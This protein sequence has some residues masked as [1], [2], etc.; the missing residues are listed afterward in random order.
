MAADFVVRFWGVRGS[1]AASGPE[2]ATVGGHT[3]CVEVRAGDEVIIFDAGTGI[4]PLAATLPTPIAAA[5]FVSHFHWDHIQGFPLFRPAYLPENAFTLYGPGDGPDGLEASLRRQ[6]QAPN[7]PVPFDALR[8][9]LRFGAI[10][11]GDEV[12]LG[13]VKVRAAALHHPQGCLGYRIAYGGASV[14][15]ATDTEQMDGLLDPALVEFARGA[16]LLICDAQYSEQEYAGTAGPCRRGW[17]HT[18]VSEASRVAR[19][20][21]VG[22]LALFHHDPSH[23][24]RQVLAMLR[25]ARVLFPQTVAACEGM[26]VDLGAGSER[27]AVSYASAA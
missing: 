9:R 11:A 8:A 20:A 13:P 18:T 26:V 25:E 10:R 21:G 7:F 27:A 3:S 19:A 22:R 2:F 23:D 14:V 1:I 4:F 16:D 15:Y 5:I 6:M 12:T 17:G 24:D